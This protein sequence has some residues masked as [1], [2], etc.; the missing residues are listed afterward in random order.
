MAAWCTRHARGV[1]IAWCAVLFAVVVVG[2][3]A[4]TRDRTEFRLP[5][6]DSQRANDLINRV[7][8]S[9]RGDYEAIVASTP[10]GVITSGSGKTSAERLFAELRQIPGV[11]SVTDPL[12]DVRLGSPVSLSHQTAI[13]VLHFRQ[14]SDDVPAPDAKQLIHDVTASRTPSF[15][16]AVIGQATE[17]AEA[18]PPPFAEIAGL[19]AAAVVLLFAFGS[20][21]TVAVAMG[22]ALAAL[23]ISFGLLQLVSH[24]ISIPYFAPQIALVIGLGVGIDYGLLTVAR[25]RGA[26]QRSAAGS[27]E[28]IAALRGAGRT[29][30]F[31]GST[32]IVAELG[33]LLTPFTLVRGLTA[34]VAIGVVPTVLA[35]NTLLPAL[36]H[37]FDG[38]LDRL[39]PRALRDRKMV[40]Y[41]SSWARWASAVQRRPVLALVGAMSVLGLLAAPA[42][43]LRLGPASGSTDNPGTMTNQ[44]YEMATNGFGPGVTSPL[45]VVATFPSAVSADSAQIQTLRSALGQTPDVMYVAPA[46][47]DQGGRH[48]MVEVIPASA[49]D[50]AATSHLR[51]DLRTRVTDQL[52]HDQIAIDVG[53]QAAIEADLATTIGHAFPLTVLAVIGTSFMLL[54]LQF[55]SVVIAAKAGVMNLLSIMAAFGVVVAVFQWGWGGHVIGVD[56]AGPI[57]S[58]LPLLLF[59]AVFGLSM[60]YE[61]FLLSRITDEWRRTHD[62]TRAIT[63]GLA[64]TGRVVTSGAAIMFVLFASMSVTG[65]RTVQLFG[66][67]LSTAVLLDATVI[68]S[69][70]LPAAMQLLGRLNWWMP[71]WL[72]R[73]V[74]RSGQESGDVDDPR[75]PRRTRRLAPSI[76]P[77]GLDRF[78]GV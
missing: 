35:A 52:Q 62:S 55:R 14:Q 9:Q 45:D 74:P 41:S 16:A 36:L 59:P 29:V 67:G 30:T 34:A 28:V 43:G 5:G 47:I 31:A 39:R 76:R 23:G 22:N 18:N 7:F 64:T 2:F 3:V 25:Y 63:D 11:T 53:G 78:G 68:R 75:R 27:P 72:D 10:H 21:V 48:A 46:L 49:P 66:L 54:L 37:L 8:P 19:L 58:F 20:M 65:D 69:V 33:L 71:A 32:V 73:L 26:R 6:T 40:E 60:D 51:T 70:L 77:F 50:V 24:E 15:Q 57:E 56:R 61:V 42:L 38:R 13:A 44:A 4:G 17:N 12:T 1:V